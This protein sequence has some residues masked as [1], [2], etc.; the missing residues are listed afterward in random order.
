MAKVFVNDSKL[1]QMFFM[2][3][4]VNMLV[5]VALGAFGAHALK[6]SLAPDLMNVYQTGNQYHFYHGLG[7]LALAVAGGI[8]KPSRL[9]WWGG[10]FMLAGIVLFSG[11]LYALAFT[12]RRWI[13]MITPFGGTG[14]LVAWALL[15]LAAWR[16]R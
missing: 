2:L 5:A 13:G 10:A 14:F 12:G 3:G 6:T 4:S 15:T 9:L 16:N 1:A 8:L 11:S 7:M